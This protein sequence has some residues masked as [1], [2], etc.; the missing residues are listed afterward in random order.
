LPKA[1]L[2]QHRRITLITGQDM[3]SPDSESSLIVEALASLGVDS[4]VVVWREKRDWSAAQL[5][6]LR[7]PW[8]YADHLT[9]FLAWVTHVASVSRLQND[10]DV[11]RWN[12]NKRY[13]LELARHGVPIVPT[14]V[15]ALGDK[16]G[17]TSFLHDFATRHRTNEIIIKPTVGINATGAV[18]AVPD[19]PA[20]AQH[21]SILLKTGDALVQPFVPAILS[22]GEVSLVFLG[23][24]YSHAVR[25]LPRA[26][27]FRVQDNHGG[28]VQ[29]YAPSAKEIETARAALAVAP[30]PTTYARVDMVDLHG[31][32]AVMEL[33]LIEPELFLRLS[34]TAVETLARRLVLELDRQSYY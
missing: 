26:G 33:E 31:T 13:L 12:L 17:P 16:V 27:D 29:A 10:A 23:S 18:R 4:E 20:L 25:K 8:D 1:Q 5:I 7:T 15:L 32:P 21:L 22:T 24:S 30:A 19:D 9:C 28:S 2:T 3:P 11:V 34:P 14:E 6:V